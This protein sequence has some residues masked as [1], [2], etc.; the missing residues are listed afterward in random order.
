MSAKAAERVQPCDR[1]DVQSGELRIRTIG[2]VK[3]GVD[4]CPRECLGYHK[5]Y[6]F[7]A[8]SLSEIVMDDRYPVLHDGQCTP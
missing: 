5:Q 1:S 6:P 8:A 7:C 4:W 2:L 3:R